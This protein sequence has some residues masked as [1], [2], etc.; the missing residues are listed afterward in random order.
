MMTKFY[1]DA[2]GRYL[3]GY[4]GAEPP[5]GAIEVP[6]PPADA[7]QVWG[8][9]AWSETPPLVPEMVT[10][11]QARAAL[12]EA[13]LFN[14]VDAHCKGAGGVTLQAW[15]YANHCYRHGALITRLA[16]AFKL[17]PADVDALFIRASQIEA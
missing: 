4:E 15:E 13:G 10:M 11:F 5:A 7:R 3:G 9:G 8:G 14:A 2:D 1:V 12:M 17:A 16:P 6:A